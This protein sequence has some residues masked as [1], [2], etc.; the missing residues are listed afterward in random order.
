MASR[1]QD[2]YQK[3]DDFRRYLATNSKRTEDLA[4]LF[5]KNSRFFGRSIL[6]IACGGGV[7]GFVAEKERRQYVGMDVNADAIS[8][9]REYARKN[10]SSCRFVLGDARKTKVVGSFDTFSLLGNALCHFST[11]EF[12]NALDN[13]SGRAKAGA[14]FIVDYRDVVQVLFRRKWARR[15]RQV[16]DGHPMTSVT[17]YC[18]TQR[19]ELVIDSLDGRGRKQ[20]EFVYG[21]WSPFII[22]PIMN[23]RGWFLVRREFERKSTLWLDVYRRRQTRQR[24]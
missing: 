3:H 22:E 16:R 23:S 8:A 2:Y 14:Y 6:D 9:A 24:S 18:D 19:G 13:L 11:G 15:F 20:L 1:V 4:R 21:V 12:A 7:L 10:G 5:S 17:K